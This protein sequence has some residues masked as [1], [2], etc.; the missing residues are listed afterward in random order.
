MI[1][2]VIGNLLESEAQALVNTVNTVGVMGKGIALQF[3]K[4]FPNNFKLYVKACKEQTFT[5]GQLLVNQEDSNLYGKK[6]IINF[7]TKTDWRKPSE[8]HYIENGLKELVKIIKEKDIKSMAIPAL[9]AGNGGLIWKNVQDLIEK[10]LTEIACEIYVY[11][12]DYKVQEIIKKE[13][14]S[15]TPARAMLLAILYDMVHY[16][17]FVSEFSSEKAVYFLQRLGAKEVF[18]LDFKPNFYGAYS[19]KV[20]HIL[21]QLN[22]SYISGYGGKDTKPFEPLSLAFD[23]ENEVLAYLQTPENTEN[24]IIVEKTKKMLANFYSSFALELLST[25]DYI[26]QKDDIKSVIEIQGKL[27]NW[28]DRKHNLFANPKFIAIALKNLEDN[29]L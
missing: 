24:A 1:H 20:K 26:V 8:Y 12:P 5:V 27:A 13:K 21:Y 22:G 29:L 10:Y 11:S 3:K 28:S 23:A 18:K 16:G 2:Y 25:V 6:I 14:V 17:E 15:L 4:T 19:G 7:P 9:G